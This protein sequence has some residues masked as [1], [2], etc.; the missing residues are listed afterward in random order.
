MLFVPCRYTDPA[1]LPYLGRDAWRRGPAPGSFVLVA[2][3]EAGEFWPFLRPTCACVAG[4][5]YTEQMIRPP[6]A[7]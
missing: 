3:D 1:L 2:C 7:A 5:R 6:G 4:L